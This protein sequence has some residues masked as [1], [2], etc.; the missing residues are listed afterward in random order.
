MAWP[1]PQRSSPHKPRIAVCHPRL[2]WG[3]SEKKV[4][5]TI[6]ALKHTYDLTL[7]TSGSLNYDDVNRYYGTALHPGDFR[8]VQV[9]LPFF[10]Q[11]ATIAAAWQGAL[12]KRFCRRLARDFEVMIS[13]YG[14]CDFG[15]PGI[16]YIADFSWSPAIRK[17]LH[18]S[19]PNW[20][21]KFGL[22]KNIYS[23]AIK[24]IEGASGLAFPSAE[25]LFISVSP[26]AS[27]KLRE[28]CGLPSQVM[29][30]PA[31][32]CYPH[33]PWSKKEPG[34]VCLGRIAPEKRIEQI[35][36][37]V[38]LL[39]EKG[40]PL[41]LHIIGGF[42]NRA[43]GRFIQRLSGK[44]PDWVFLEGRLFEKDK[45]Q[46]LACHRYGLHAC[47]GDAFPGAVVEMIMAGCIPFVSREGG[48]A[49][50]V[51]H[52]GLIFD[53]TPEAVRKIVAFLNDEPSP[54]RVQN[55]LKKQVGQYSVDIFLSEIKRTVKQFLEKSRPRPTLII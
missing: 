8:I 24:K 10:L 55:H 37:I 50:V 6:E 38:S 15:M 36:K 39:R 12:Y 26:W 45:I 17:A 30:T 18:P 13:G 51:G 20:Y 7:I 25:D 47:Y 53:D 41:H 32:G 42:E 27:R 19:P 33:I 34:F 40:H 23:W 14:P 43:Y 16:H 11:K 29:Y 48:Q 49:D 2:S 3:G 1:V 21:H 4:L 5:W 9:P 28:A 54:R 52:P 22:W 35:I 46:M 44:N 31:V